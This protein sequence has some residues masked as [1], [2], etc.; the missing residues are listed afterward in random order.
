MFEAVGD[1]IILCKL[2]NKAQPGTIDP[3]AINVKKPLNVFNKNVLFN[4]EFL[5]QL[6]LSHR[7]CQVNWCYR[8]ECETQRHY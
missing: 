6:E 8:G 1:G 2:I 5:D 4:L 3:R 7:V